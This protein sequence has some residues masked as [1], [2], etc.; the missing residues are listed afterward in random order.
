MGA[1]ELRTRVVHTTAPS[2]LILGS[3]VLLAAQPATPVQLAHACHAVGFDQVLPASW[4]DELVAQRALERLRDTELPAIQCS[5]P[6]VAQ[7]LAAYAADL[8][9]MLIRVVPPVIALARHLRALYAPTPISVTFAGS[10]PAGADA[11][12]DSWM[13]PDELLTLLDRRG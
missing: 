1:A 11:I 10:C 13:T 12:I 3:D 5:C 7:R 9:P 8:A 4:G 2:L 6:W